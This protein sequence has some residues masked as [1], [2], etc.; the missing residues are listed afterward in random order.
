[1][2]NYRK[3]ISYLGLNLE[4]KIQRTKR[5]NTKKRLQNIIH[6]KGETGICFLKNP[7]TNTWPGPRGETREIAGD[8]G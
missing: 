7:P 4:E 2:Q 8:K 5:A 3:E 6:C 1:M